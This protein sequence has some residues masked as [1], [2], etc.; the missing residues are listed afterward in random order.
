MPQATFRV[1]AAI[2]ELTPAHELPN[3]NDSPVR[4]DP[5]A[6][7]LSCHAVAFD[8]GE[9][10]GAI[11]SCDATFVDRALLLRLRDVCEHRTGIPGP[12]VL[13]TATHTHACPATCPSFLSGALPDPVY[14]DFLVE[15]IAEAVSRA[16]A[17]LAPAVLVSGTCPAPGFEFNRRLVRPNGL[18][19]MGG[20]GNAA[21]SL[22]PAGPVDT[23]M[24]FL[25][26]E[27]LSGR[28]IALAVNYACHNNCVSDVFHADIAGRMGEAIRDR[29]S[30]EVATPF[31]PAPCG[32][33]IWRATG[34]GHTSG[35]E[36]A[37]EIGEAIAGL[38]MPAY[39]DAPRQS[40]DCAHVFRDV[41][42]IPDRPWEESTFC[43]DLCRGNDDRA[44][45]F[46][47]HRYDPEEAAVKARGDTV[48]PVEIQGMAFG[49]TAV[50]TNPA[51]LFVKFGMEIRDRSPFATTIVSE[52]SNG[53]CG[54]V[55]DVNDF[56]QQGYE[57]HRTLYTCRLAKHA[58]RL[59]ADASV[60]MLHAL[61]ATDSWPC[62]RR[63]LQW[64]YSVRSSANIDDRRRLQVG[65]SR[66]WSPP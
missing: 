48:C 55:G 34:A 18:V 52:L 39:R 15:R 16:V 61:R 28:P 30:A 65:G 62:R 60:A 26:F 25:A 5:D 59:I 57:T 33:V 6:S 56:E 2:T 21:P 14:V 23:Q 51:E 63:P 46:A 40:V 27:D 8:D 43:H 47:R 10:K 3:Y 58:G 42:E 9:M 19:V 1:G 50:V 53:Y 32:D 37:T 35:D 38:V 45:Q 29:L 54:Y 66:R 7:P 49:D 11:V 64:A 12:N 36:R 17:S 24:P 31:L 20:A 22:P 13:L 44:K 4:P 41:M